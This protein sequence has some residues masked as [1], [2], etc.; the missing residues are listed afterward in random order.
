VNAAP[1]WFAVIPCSVADLSRSSPGGPGGPGLP[2]EPVGPMD[3]GPDRTCWSN[4]A[5]STG[6]TCYT[7]GSWQ[8]PAGRW[9]LVVLGA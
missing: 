5:D 9:Y 8:A 3:L 1:V 2:C 7:H 6:W 4:R